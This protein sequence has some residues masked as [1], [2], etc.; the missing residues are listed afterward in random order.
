MSKAGGKSGRALPRTRIAIG[1]VV[2]ALIVVVILVAVN[3]LGFHYYERWDFSR[4]QKFRL[5]MQTKQALRELQKPI[6][7]TVYFSP[8]YFG[9]ESQL[10]PDVVNLLKELQFSGR[11]HVNIEFVDPMRNLDRARELQTRHRFGAEENVVIVEYG[12]NVQFVDIGEMGDFDTTP[13]MAGEPPRVAAFRGEQVLTSA[14]V[15]LLDPSER[16]MYMLQG[17]G[18]PSIGP[19]SPLTILLDHIER[20]NVEVHPLNLAISP[21]VPEDAQAVVIIGPRY[22]LPE[23]ELEA[24][25]SYWRESGRILLLLDPEATT[26]NFDLLAAGAGI[27]PL[28]TR[29]LRTVPLGFAIGIL[30]EVVGEFSPESDVTKRLEGV[31]AYFPEHTQSLALEAE[32]AEAAGIQLRPLI[33]AHEEYWGEVD[34]VTDETTGVSYDEGRDDGYPVII[35]AAADKGGIGDERVGIQ[36]SKMVV[37]GNS[38][39]ARDELIGGPA[40]DTAN[41]DFL[42]SSLNW[43]MDRARLTGV[44]PKVPHEFRL[45]LTDRQM[46]NIA[47][48]TMVLIPGTAGLL[49]V[50]VWLRRRK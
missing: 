20:Q 30:R 32:I 50:L 2:Q 39:F 27:V 24:L 31:N 4:S 23:R 1:V 45:T 8:T 22:D 12:N 49:G 10:Y 42:V 21:T 15:G 28:D 25:I 16:R 36:S 26:P 9:P 19:D 37:V 47:L 40:G 14:M 48:Y 41:L 43:M 35:A 7:F 44:V 6:Y 38:E 46:G 5:A 34:H 17:H 13:M 29:V 3:Y 18:E 11:P 33:I